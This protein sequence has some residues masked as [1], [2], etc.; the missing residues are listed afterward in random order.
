MILSAQRRL[1]ETSLPLSLCM[2]GE[3]TLQAYISICQ[4]LHTMDHQN[5]TFP[6]RLQ[7][8]IL[9]IV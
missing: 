4:H 7:S 3:W 1:H 8:D 6:F 2:L 5:C 9:T